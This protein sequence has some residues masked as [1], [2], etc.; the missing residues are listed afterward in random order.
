MTDYKTLVP[1]EILNSEELYVEAIR[2]VIAP[3]KLELKIFDQD[4]SH[5]GFNSIETSELIH[6]FITQNANSRLTIILHSTAFLQLKC[7][8]LINLI[9]VYG[10]KITVYETNPSAK[11]AKDCFII[12][13]A[14]HY[15]KRIHIDQARF[16]YNL[17]DSSNIN[18]LNDRFQDLLDE[19][20]NILTLTTLGL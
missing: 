14:E 6:Q 18:T 3:A 9:K 10:H 13:D 20:E 4:L 11:V 17:N 16:K 2:R 12:A 19:T 1:G 5:G 15:I 7:L 8:R